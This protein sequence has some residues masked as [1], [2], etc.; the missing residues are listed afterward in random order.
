MRE[1][2]MAGARGYS[3]SPTPRATS[4]PPSRRSPS[5]SP[6]SA[7]RFPRPSWRVLAR[8]RGQAGGRRRRQPH[9]ARAGGAAAPCR[10]PPQQG[11]R[12]AARSLGQDGGNAPGGRYGEDQG[13]HIADL[14][15]YAVR[16]R[17]IPTYL[18]TSG[19]SGPDQ[20]SGGSGSGSRLVSAPA[21]MPA[22]R[23][24]QHKD[25][26]GGREMTPDRTRAIVIG[27]LPAAPRTHSPAQ[28][29]RTRNDH[30]RTVPAKFP[31]D[32]TPEGQC[33]TAPSWPGRRAALLL[34]ASPG[35]AQVAEQNFPRRAHQRPLRPCGASGQEALAQAALG[36]CQGYSSP[37]ASTTGRSARR[38]AC[39]GPFSACRTRRRPSTRRL[40]PRR[41]GRG[42]I[43]STGASGRSTASP[44]LPR[45]RIPARTSLPSAAPLIEEGRQTV[46]A[47]AFLSSWPLSS[48]SA[49]AQA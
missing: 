10:G 41:H 46:L 45:K 4:S 16:N 42:T 35:D 17:I 15:R 19:I 43:H 21:P 6:S 13:G 2:F 7:R 48:R 39:T 31:R 49:V 1:V 9:A 22:A 12:T 28:A 37:L 5:T 11:V 25:L 27:L 20:G 47:I 32:E 18:D 34:A 3:S 29:L 38:A 33:D 40:V 36:Y 8:G 24:E 26:S 23:G 14:V 30:T 44:V